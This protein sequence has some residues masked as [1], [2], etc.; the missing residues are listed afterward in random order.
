[1]FNRLDI[2]VP[3]I[4]LVAAI[5]YAWLGLYA[6]RRRP[7]IAVT[8]FAQV[9][10]GM[11]IWTLMYS[12]ELF[13]SS[14]PAKLFFTEIEYIGI[15]IAPV[16]M[17]FFAI[18][19]T[20]KRH[21]LNTG[22]KL[23][24]CIIPA[25]AIALAWT[26]EFHY[27]MWDNASLTN[28]GRLVLL[29]LDFGFFFWLHISYTYLL[30]IIASIVLIMEF[31]QRPG[32]YRVQISFVI[33]SIIFPVIGSIIYVT[34]SGLIKNLDVTPL[35]FLPT[36]VGLSWAIVKYR[37]LEILPLEH[38][39]I[40]ENM[41]DSVIVVNPQFRVLY[42]NPTA[43]QV[44]QSVEEKAIGQPFEKVSA[45]YSEKIIPYLLTNT[46]I[47]TEVT[48]GENKHTRVY[49]L[50]I[51]SV[52]PL[53]QSQ[54]SKQSDKIIILHDITERKETETA[55]IRREIIM[56]S[57]S[58][59]AEHFLRESNW[60]ENVPRIL[61]K[62]G[63][64]ADV[65]RISVVMNHQDEQGEIYSSLRYE[66][67]LSSATPQINNLALKDVPLRKSGLS[68]WEDWLSQG[69][70]IDGI[71]KNLPQEEQNFYK[72]RESLSIAVV[73]IFVK[74]QWWGFIL[75]DECRYE[76]IWASSE[77]ES[78]QLVANIFGSAETR[79]RNEQILINRQR[80]LE[81]LHE[82]VKVA[83]KAE[84]IKTM[85][86]TIV[87][88]L[89]ALINADGCF[90]TLWDE[91]NKL[92]IPIA[93]YG[94][95][96][97]MYAS[98][99]TKS[100]EHTFTE[101]VLEAGHT[102]VVE[103]I[104]S[105]TKIEQQNAQ[106]QSMLALPL[107][108]EEKK[109]GAVILTFNKTHQFLEDEIS[110][111]EQA[112]AVI[113]LALEKFQAMEEA[114]RRAIKSENLRKATV[115]ISETLKSDTAIEKILEQLNVVIPYDSASVQLIEGNELKIVGG[116]G[117]PMIKEVLEMRFPIPG[118]NPNTV[119]IE[120]GK[121]YI[122]RDAPSVYKAF[123]ELQNNHI[124]S[125]LGIPLIAQY[126][127]IGLL[128]IDSSKPNRFTDED[129]NLAS[130]FADQ[131]AVVLENARMFEEKQEQ[132]I[133]DTLTEIYNRRG[134]IELGKIEFE[135]ALNANKK[136][137]A[138]M[139]DVDHF[140]N[141]NDSYGHEVGDNVL[142]EFAFRCKKCVREIDLV[143]RYG[144]EE[145]VLL[146]PNTGIELGIKI[147]NRLCGLIADT[148]FKISENLE[149]NVTAS[150]GVACIDANT[151][152]LDILINRAD[153]AMYIAKHKGRNQVK[154]NI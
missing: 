147:A 79:A 65:S 38:I 110:I 26:N 139:A 51:S 8:S 143:G 114:Q 64:A 15:A 128:A 9:M 138:I 91:A 144:G 6:W 71:I 87:E 92:T 52:M 20:G 57:I 97:D 117:F 99:Q 10:L 33:L 93:A 80:T 103:D 120:T 148:P 150:L 109:L 66:W 23:L 146:L 107:I 84:D 28:V 32:V 145:I 76:R 44:L 4:Y 35:F 132:A 18:E 49:E 25:L 46:E 121:P 12:L 34:S 116:K 98:I 22:R 42:I 5:P 75:F 86:Q 88:R 126:K 115:A 41:K 131:V 1:M 67:T 11:S 45:T 13:S 58:T 141:I 56:S 53:G 29:Q 94:P 101:S 19:F 152:N 24:I 47:A 7:A 62:I 106:T 142:Q 135:K 31:I 104:N 149:I 16:A 74:Y 39:T 125:W 68:R 136:F 134:L 30:L 83:L 100:G 102:L 90:L 37:L 73:P 54:E 14:I 69:L 111:C 2:Y 129:A 123:R 151:M 154:Y 113:A 105:I 72:G 89:G 27:L 153:Q 140:K 122:L 130:I 81:L 59:A 119:V 61:E 63:K 36:S 70:T 137:S 50:N 43:E 82:I 85:A 17:L 78:F 21:V 124:H 95:Q 48:I 3:L 77:L 127:I 133:I 96:K 40:L 118:D 60:I 55:L 108:A 112:S